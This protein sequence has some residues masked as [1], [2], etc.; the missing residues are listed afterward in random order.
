MAADQPPPVTGTAPPA[1]RRPGGALR[2]PLTWVII[3]GAALAGGAVLLWRSKSAA[4]SSSTDTTGTTAA[5]ATDYS[6]AIA[7]LQSEIADLQSSVAQQSGG[8]SGTSGGT[9]SGGAG[10][11]EVT[12][13]NVVGM[14]SAQAAAALTAAGLKAGPQ[15]SR[16]GRVNSQTPGAGAKV[17]RGST[18]DIGVEGDI[19]G[20]PPPPAAGRAPAMPTAVVASAVSGGGATLRWA[21]V[22]GATSYRVRLTYQGKQA[23]DR[24]TATNSARIS[25]LTPGHTYTAHVASIGPG[26]TSGETNGPV[27]HTRAA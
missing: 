13:P 26:G 25:G 14:G 6:G 22:P 8:S 12:V 11:D 7:T 10:T 19:S 18:V 15:A 1:S 3:L 27:V 21:K 16:P 5:D 17:P 20:N 23:Y 9:G 2:S 4:A 24:T